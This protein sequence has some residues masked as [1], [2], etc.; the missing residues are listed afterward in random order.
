[1]DF[2]C[3]TLLQFNWG[4]GR[5]EQLIIDLQNKEIIDEFEV[6]NRNL[7]SI[8]AEKKYFALMC[9]NH[10]RWQDIYLSLR[11]HPYRK[12]DRFDN[13]INIF[14]FS[15][16]ENIR[17]SFVSSLTISDERIVK[18]SP[19]GE[20]YEVNRYCPHQGADLSDVE[21][22]EQNEI[23]CPRHS[24]CFSLDQLGKSLNSSHTICAK[25]L[26]PTP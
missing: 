6:S 18:V 5:D 14:L 15:D 8:K 22:N 10:H 9:S 26:K 2:Q 12:P 7:Y 13:Y 19:N 25:K 11:A 23:V 16:P 3:E 21:I 20:C 1:L 4:D 24:W 17:E